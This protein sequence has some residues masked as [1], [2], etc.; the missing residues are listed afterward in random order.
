VTIRK[1]ILPSP[2]EIEQ[3]IKRDASQ[4]ED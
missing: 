1:A 2:A 4:G 3:F